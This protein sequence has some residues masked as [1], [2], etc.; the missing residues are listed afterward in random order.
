LRA[1]ALP[2]NRSAAPPRGVL[3]VICHIHLVECAQL[4]SV[5]LHDH[6]AGGRGD[7][8]HGCERAVVDVVA[9]VVSPG[10]DAVSGRVLAP[11]DE[12]PVVWQEAL[13]FELCAGGAVG[14]L[15]SVVVPR[16]HHRA[17]GCVLEAGGA[18]LLDQL[19][20]ARQLAL[21]DRD[22]LLL[23]GEVLVGVAVARSAWRA[24]RS[25]AWCCRIACRSVG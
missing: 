24:S 2:L 7:L 10:D 16:D 15:A 8:R 19:R 4:S 12:H 25:S 1:G 17:F 3:E 13:A 23:V 5:G 18:P 21:M 22:C 9:A 20:D 11:A 14:E 6:R